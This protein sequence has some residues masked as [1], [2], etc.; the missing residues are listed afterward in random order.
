MHESPVCDQ[1][2]FKIRPLEPEGPVLVVGPPDDGQVGG[3]LRSRLTHRGVMCVA[4]QGCDDAVMMAERYGITV[5]A[6]VLTPNAADD[7]ASVLRTMSP[8]MG[9]IALLAASQLPAA[10]AQERSWTIAADRQMNGA[11]VLGCIEAVSRLAPTGAAPRSL[12]IE[13]RR[14]DRARRMLGALRGASEEAVRLAGAGRTRDGIARLMGRFDEAVAFGQHRWILQ[15]RDA[16][17]RGDASE[18]WRGIGRLRMRMQGIEDAD[19]ASGAKHG[20][21]SRAVS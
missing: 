20:G 5:C 18:L 19:S 16:M 4:A 13:E 3:V 9:V 7:L 15:A 21:D 2:V 11:G 14:A 8:G 12:M 10:H 1:A 6:L 17:E